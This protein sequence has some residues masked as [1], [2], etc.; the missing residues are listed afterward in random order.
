LRQNRSSTSEGRH[1]RH[2]VHPHKLPFIQPKGQP[3]N[4]ANSES[5]T[6]KSSPSGLGRVDMSLGYGP[7]KDEQ[8]TVQ[9][10]RHPEKLEQMTGR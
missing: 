4:N 9:G 1:T 6:W 2:A 10:A 3:C 8:V 5:A 7:L